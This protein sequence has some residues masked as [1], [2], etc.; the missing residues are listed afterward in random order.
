M[1][2]KSRRENTVTTLNDALQRFIVRGTANGPWFVYDRKNGMNIRQYSVRANAV[3][4]AA[5][6][7]RQDEQS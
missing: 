6:R 7:N 5:N 2:T 4:Y 1:G 3:E